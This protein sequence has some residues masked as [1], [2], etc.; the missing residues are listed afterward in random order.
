MKKNPGKNTS[1]NYGDI[2]SMF[3]SGAKSKIENSIKKDSEIKVSKEKQ[4]TPPK[5]EKAD[6]IKNAEEV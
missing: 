3:S 4:M 2:K 6:K 5:K 1:G